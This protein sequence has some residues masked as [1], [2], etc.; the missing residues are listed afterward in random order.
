MLHVLVLLVA[1]VALFATEKLPVELVSLLIL[2]ILLLIAVAGPAMGMVQADKWITLQDGLSGLSNPAVVTVA[3]MFVLSAGLEKTGALGAVGRMFIRVGRNQTALMI[4]IM[5]GVGVVSAF[6]NNTATVAVFLPL[7]LLVCARYNVPPSRMLIPLSFAS[8]FGGVCTLIGTSTNLLVSSISQ[9]AGYGAFSMFEF[10]PLGLIL[11]GVGTVYLLVAGRWLI[12]ARRSAQL[13]ETYQLREYLTEVRVLPDSPLI[14][15]TVAESK[16]GERHD[17]NVLEILRGE[18]RI[19]TPQ[20]AQLTAGDILLV[21]GK[22][23][24]LMDLR[25]ST[26]LE[27]EPE[28]QLKDNTLEKQD[29]ILAEALVSPRSALAGR[30][31]ASADFRWRYGAIVLALQR[32]GHLLREKLAS[33]RLRF[34]DALLLLLR[35]QDLPHLQTNDNLIMLSEVDTPMRRKGKALVALAIIGAVVSV[36]AATGAPIL[37]CAILGAL[38]MVLT[39]CLSIEQAYR[40]IDWKV[41]FLLAGVLPLGIALERSGGAQFLADNALGRMGQFGPIA[42]LATIYLLTAILTEVMSNNASAVLLAPIAISTAINLGVDP[43]PMLMA[44]TF[45]ASTSFATPVGYQTNTMVYGAGGYRFAD[46]IRVGLPLNVIFWALAVW[47]IPR[48]WPF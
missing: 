42:A 18:R 3:A 19:W 32:Q 24:S 17:V 37:V 40:A 11:L 14:G 35:K 34:G 12:P 33:V 22:V 2:G 26:G 43:K 23:K 36:A 10:G 21:R 5:L 39:N 45:A 25:S 38:A 47:F 46:F 30:T 31:L 20:D 13:A 28:F 44:V 15:K 29:L 8:Q 27:I 41:I 6:I 9:K 1:A 16:L 48:F 7:V 4:V